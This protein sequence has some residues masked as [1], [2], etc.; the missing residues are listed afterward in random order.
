M[1]NSNSP[2][3]PLADSS[4]PMQRYLNR[5]LSQNDILK[6]KEAF[7]SFDPHN[8]YIEVLKVKNNALNSQD[9]EAID[10]LIGFKRQINFEE[11]FEMSS[12]MIREKKRNHPNVEIDSNE[13]QATCLFCPY[14]ED[15]HK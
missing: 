15:G 8:G 6:V 14:T 1:G 9:K 10:S 5:G 12:V 13:V 2:S 11:F 7:D 3:T 4:F